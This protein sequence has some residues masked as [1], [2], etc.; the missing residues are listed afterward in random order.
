MLS[1]R[2]TAKLVNLD[3]MRLIRLYQ[4]LPKELVD[5]NVQLVL[6]SPHYQPI[7]SVK[8]LAALIGCSKYKALRLVRQCQV[9]L[10]HMGR[11]RI[12]LLSDLDKLNQQ[13]DWIKQQTIE[14]KF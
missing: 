3:K 4:Q 13:G 2:S 6:A 11:K 9:P 10:Y 7:Y 14:N 12:I 8:E 1:L 5:L